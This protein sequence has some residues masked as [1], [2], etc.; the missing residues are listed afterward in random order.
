MPQR[1]SAS[2][3]YGKA[4]SGRKRPCFPAANVDR[5]FPRRRRKERGMFPRPK[6]PP[7]GAARS[8][9]SARG[10]GARFKAVISIAL[11]VSS[12]GP[13]VTHGAV[14]AETLPPPEVVQI[15]PG[16]APGTESWTGGEQDRVAD[17]AGQRV[18]TLSN[19]TR[20]TLTIYRPASPNG[21]AVIIA[22]GGSFQVL[23]VTQEGE[24]VA[25]WLAQRGYTALVLKYRVRPGAPVRIPPDLR[26]RPEA[27]GALFQ[28]I[29][30]GRTIAVADGLQA[31]RF[32][33]GNASRLGVASN[34][35]GFMGFSAGAITTMGVVMDSRPEDRPNFAASLYGAMEHKAPPQAGPPV[36]VAAAQDDMTVPVA[37]SLR[38]F[39]AWTDANLR[40]EL[41]VYERGGHGFGMG[42]RGATVDTWPTAFE[43]WLKMQGFA[44]PAV[45]GAQ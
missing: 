16:A 13:G 15:W 1:T 20:P 27:W 29:G 45:P 36:F 25:K 40:A 32:V 17:R 7:V 42:P 30:P 38:I 34:R 6:E 19:V 5:E 12:V 33:R 4:V 21:T 3:T 22:P 14:A 24:A 35:I 44:A 11:W 43:A 8:R 41:H 10:L 2:V 26:H 31:M 23:A 18:H 37:E 39:S 28:S 9:R